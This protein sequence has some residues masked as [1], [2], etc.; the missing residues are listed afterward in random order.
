MAGL[1]RRQIGGHT[2]D[3]LGACAVIV[4]GSVLSVLAL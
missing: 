4:E 3:V 2:G 1:A